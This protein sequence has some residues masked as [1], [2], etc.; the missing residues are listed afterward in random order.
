M[1]SMISDQVWF[2]SRENTV[3]SSADDF[4]L[5]K[6]QEWNQMAR[7]APKSIRVGSAPASSSLWLI[8]GF[9]QQ[10]QTRF[11]SAIDL[12]HLQPAALIY[13]IRPSVIK[14]A[15]SILVIG[16]SKSQDWPCTVLLV[17]S[18]C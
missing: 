9:L 8:I 14:D 1:T 11:K 16:C 13:W 4:C 18:Q 10:C 15:G 5:S 6:V 3:G 12:F 7:K 2:S 17:S